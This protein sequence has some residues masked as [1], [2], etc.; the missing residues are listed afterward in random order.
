MCRK[1]IHIA[2]SSVY[3]IPSTMKVSLS[4]LGNYSNA[5]WAICSDSWVGV[6]SSCPAA[7]PVLPISNRPKQNQA[8]GGTVKI[9]ANPT[10]LSEQMALP[11]RVYTFLDL[12]LT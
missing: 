10:Q 2:N 12:L 6:P 8:E 3:E 7:Q 5:G 9:K 4:F 1:S 11:V